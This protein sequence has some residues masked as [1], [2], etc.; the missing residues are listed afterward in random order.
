[1]IA[2]NINIHKKKAHRKLQPTQCAVSSFTSNR[3]R[4]RDHFLKS[5]TIHRFTQQRAGWRASTS[6]I[7]PKLCC[8]VC[9]GSDSDEVACDGDTRDGDRA[10]K[11][12][13][14]QLSRCGGCDARIQW[15]RPTV[16]VLLLLGYIVEIWIYFGKLIQN[17][18]Y[19]KSPVR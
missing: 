2:N 13:R 11:I 6:A 3:T 15:R 7:V 4:A 16:G 18:S 5:K 12:A 8:V 9:G 1:M 19:N 10:A 14:S 17:V